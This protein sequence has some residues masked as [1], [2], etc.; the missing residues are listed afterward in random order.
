MGVLYH[1]LH[2]MLARVGLVVPAALPDIDIP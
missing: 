1:L 2:I